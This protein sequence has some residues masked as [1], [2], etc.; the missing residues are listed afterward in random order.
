[1]K[2]FIMACLLF[3]FSSPSY[4][5]NFP[6]PHLGI[7]VN[8]HQ[9]PSFLVGLRFFPARSW[10]SV[11]GRA[12]F[13]VKREGLT[14]GVSSFHPVLPFASARYSSYSDKTESYQIGVDY[15][16]FSVH[17]GAFK[18]ESGDLSALASVEVSVF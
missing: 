6:L 3:L 15:I 1:M 16:S 5:G 18:E 7:G 4:G 17:A 14:V 2:K 11:L 8:S 10:V 12:E 13:G 9:G